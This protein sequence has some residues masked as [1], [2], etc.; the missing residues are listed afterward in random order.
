VFSA[1]GRVK[2][3]TVL[4]AKCGQEYGKEHRHSADCYQEEQHAEGS[5]YLDWYEGDERLR[6][7][8]GRSAADANARLLSK[9]VELSAIAAG[10]QVVGQD[11][12]GRTTLAVAIQE[13]STRDQRIGRKRPTSIT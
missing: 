5:Y 11:G 2:P 4:V 12:K 10:V 1:N 7:S 3:D 8:V 6:L 13:F 9:A